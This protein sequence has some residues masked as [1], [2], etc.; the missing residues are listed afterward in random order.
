MLVGEKTTVAEKPAIEEKKVVVE[1][2]IP[3][4]E[5]RQ[6]S[7][8][9]LSTI[10]KVIKTTEETPANPVK[11]RTPDRPIDE[12]I[13][14]RAWDQFLELRKSNT[15]ELP[16]IVLRRPYVLNG[17]RIIVSII[18]SVEEMVFSTMRTSL[19]TFLRDRTGNSSLLIESNLIEEAAVERKAY[20]AK[21]KFEYLASKNPVLRDMKERFGL[22]PDLAS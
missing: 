4:Q 22:D 10:G 12:E 14:K 1:T 6:R 8:L 3:S 13:L 11:E 17:T 20:T 19:T 21:E 9:N 2:K 16:L 5:G 7:T 15:D 18:K